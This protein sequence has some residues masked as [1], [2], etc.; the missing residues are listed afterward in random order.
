MTMQPSVNSPSYSPLYKVQEMMDYL[1]Q[2]YKLAFEAGPALSLD[3][4][5][6]RA[7]GRIKFK[8]RII[9]KSARYGNKIYVLADARTSYVLKVLVYTGQYTYTNTPERNEDLK[10]TV[11]VCKELCMPFRG[12][13]RVVYVDHFYTSIEL[14]KVVKRR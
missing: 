9:T 3:E 13:H 1:A 2:R 11:K 7:F 8:V 4:S 10:K 14:I 6:I 5:L 12:S